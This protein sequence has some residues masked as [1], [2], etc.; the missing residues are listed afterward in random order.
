MAKK[1]KDKKVEATIK[2]DPK[3]SPVDIVLQKDGEKDW[4]AKTVEVESK[5]KLEDDKGTGDA[6][7]IRAFTFGA[8]VESFKRNKPTAQD[9]FNSHI[10]QME[11]EMWKDGWSVFPEVPPRMLF[12]VNG[13][14]FESFSP[15]G[16]QYTH[17]RI[18]LAAKPAKGSLLSPSAQPKTLSQIAHDSSKNRK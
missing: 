8:N 5:T 10:K 6:I 13:Q 4:E 2:N 9:L 11:I 3:E 18:I 12:S 17:Y 7:S 1:K 16:K 15:I 14:D